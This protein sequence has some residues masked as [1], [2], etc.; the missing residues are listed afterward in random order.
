MLIAASFNLSPIY[1]FRESVVV[2]SKSLSRTFSRSWVHFL[3]GFRL[4]ET[5]YGWYPVRLACEYNIFLG[6][7]SQ[8]QR[9][10]I[11]IR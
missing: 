9:W 11:N 8:Y 10:Q 1:C 6:S 7:A 5:P 4:I 3:V 2:S